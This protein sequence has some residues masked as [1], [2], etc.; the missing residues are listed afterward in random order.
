ML[1]T[2]LC[3]RL[4]PM[5]NIFGG[6]KEIKCWQFH[7]VQLN[8]FSSLIPT[9]ALRVGGIGSTPIFTDEKTEAQNN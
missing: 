5:K 3:I 8:T 9:M 6:Q 2:V 7:M 1:D 4:N